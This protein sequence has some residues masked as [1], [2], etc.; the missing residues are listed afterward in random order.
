M[1]TFDLILCVGGIEC[2]GKTTTLDFLETALKK[3]GH[4]VECI[5]EDLTAFFTNN[6]IKTY[7]EFCKLSVDRRRR[8][9][10]TVMDIRM[11]LEKSLYV[12]DKEE[13][14]SEIDRLPTNKLK[15]LLID[16]PW[17]D[18][19]H[20]MLRR[21]E[22]LP[23]IELTISDVICKLL[24]N[25]DIVVYPSS[26]IIL[27]LGL[28]PL[29]NKVMKEVDKDKRDKHVFKNS[30][31]DKLLRIKNY[32]D[33]WLFFN[34]MLDVCKKEKAV[35]YLTTFFLEKP[36]IE[37]SEEIMLR[38]FPNEDIMNAVKKEIFEYMRQH[39][40]PEEKFAWKT[41]SFDISLALLHE[42]VKLLY[43]NPKDSLISIKEAKDIVDI[44]IDQITISDMKERDQNIQIVLNMI[45]DLGFKKK[46]AEELIIKK[47]FD[48][49]TQNIDNK[50]IN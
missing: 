1:N 30:Y 31:K 7:E 48:M 27:F 14:E 17:W 36:T 3:E 46:E 29:S 26:A 20:Y 40:I 49:L 2:S 12:E 15:I 11:F 50:Y 22:A 9:A 44:I 42:I 39:N 18:A 34:L 13:L 16:A 6:K 41:N 47:K 28:N 38:L 8:S 23:G 19:M 10:L 5:R 35:S 4:T 21:S 24:I 37:F 45:S 33:Y 32:V 43:A 25:K